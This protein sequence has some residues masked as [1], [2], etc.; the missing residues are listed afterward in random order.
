MLKFINSEQEYIDATNG[1]GRVLKKEIDLVKNPFTKEF[2]IFIGFE[3]D[4]IYS[5]GFYLSLQKF[6]E[7]INSKEFTFY[8]LVPEPDDY[9]FAHFS[10]Y[11]IARV[12]ASATYEEYIELLHQDPGDS[13]A[14]A[15][16]H[17]AETVAMYSNEAIWGI[18]GSKDLE[19]GIVGF[20]DEESKAKFMSCFEKNVFT[21]IR[22]RLSDLDE[23]L[24]LSQ[25]TK[26]IHSQ[27]IQNYSSKL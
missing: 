20:K 23:A 11:S 5:Q 6:L 19:I 15:L 2:S 26:A 10:K 12:G 27:I 14:D 1:L 18:I 3:F 17:N 9:F 13:S 24:K 8:T 4:K 22:E 16:I 21:D 7:K 25:E